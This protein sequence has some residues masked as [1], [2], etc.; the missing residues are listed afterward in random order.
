[1]PLKNMQGQNAACSA[2]DPGKKEHE[3][4]QTLW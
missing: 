4:Q 1:M 2:V 3:K